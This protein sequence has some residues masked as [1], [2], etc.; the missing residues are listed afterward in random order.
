MENNEISIHEVRIYRTFTQSPDKWLT[1]QEVA[2]LSDVAGRTARLHTK[3]LVSIGVLD[4]AEVF[5]GHRYRLSEKA[6]KRDAGYVNRLQKASEV[7]G[8]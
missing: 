3:R 6:G 1:N 8:I 5:P 4:V 7:F 2:S